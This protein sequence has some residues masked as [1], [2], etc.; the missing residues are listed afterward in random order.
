MELKESKESLLLPSTINLIGIVTLFV[1]VLLCSLAFY[2][3]PSGDDYFALALRQTNTFKTMQEYIYTN[4]G[5]RYTSNF[6]STAFTTNSFLLKCYFLHTILLFTLS[7]ISTANLLIV[8]NKFYLKNVLPFSHILAFASLIIVTTIFCLPE[9]N[10][11]FYWFSSSITYQF[12]YC[13]FL[14]T[15]SALITFLNQEKKQKLNLVFLLL[16]IVM[17]NGTNE[18]AALL[19]GVIGSLLII[20]TSKKKWYLVIILGTTYF[21]S[22]LISL[23][24]PGNQLRL[25]LLNDSDYSITSSF[26][27]LLLQL[28]HTQQVLFSS[29]LFILINAIFFFYGLFHQQKEKIF[30]AKKNIT[31]KI[32]KIVLCWIGVLSFSLFPILIPSRGSLPTRALNIIISISSLFFICLSFYIGLLVKSESLLFIVKHRLFNKLFSLAFCLTLFFNPQFADLLKSLIA[33]PAY[34]KTMQHRE[35]M[36][37]SNRNSKTVDL[38]SINTI[39]DSIINVQY[40]SQ[41]QIVKEIMNTKPKLLFVKDDIENEFNKQALAKYYNIANIQTNK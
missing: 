30:F 10:T 19:T 26:A 37:T 41:R 17:T 9:I 23:L 24:S 4:W 14:F 15:I 36:L 12:S 6:L 11:A 28:I 33:A 7:Y 21:S 29:V 8:I 18:L 3:M 38:K 27:S 39:L 35:M 16:M 31:K 40:I 25:N 32:V 5:G 13:C 34:K 20:I 2:N 1:C 22:L